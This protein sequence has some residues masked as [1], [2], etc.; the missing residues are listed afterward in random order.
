MGARGLASP[1]AK[2]I[3]PFRTRPPGRQ[4]TFIFM[5]CLLARVLLMSQVD[6]IR[7]TSGDEARS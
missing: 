3:G 2:I 1:I 7:G 6:R 4:L 5:R